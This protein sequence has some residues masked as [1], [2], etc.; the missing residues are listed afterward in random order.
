MD[1]LI[2]TKKKKGRL[3]TSEVKRTSAKLKRDSCSNRKMSKGV[4]T[5][6]GKKETQGGKEGVARNN[7]REGEKNEDENQGEI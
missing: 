2:L 7:N 3:N 5:A 1:R 4:L 6:S